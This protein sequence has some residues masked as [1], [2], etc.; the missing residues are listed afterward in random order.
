[1]MRLLT[2]L[3]A[4]TLIPLFAA[5]RLAGRLLPP[6][7]DQR[8]PDDESAGSSYWKDFN[9]SYN[10]ASRE[11][12]KSWLK[13]EGLTIEDVLDSGLRKESARE[14]TLNLMTG[15]REGF[16][17]PGFAQCLTYA[18]SCAVIEQRNEGFGR[19]ARLTA[20]WPCE[21]CVF[22]KGLRDIVL[23]DPDA[24]NPYSRSGNKLG[25]C[26]RHGPITM[27]EIRPGS[28]D[29]FTPER[30]R[31]LM[32]LK[33]ANEELQLWYL[34]HRHH[35]SP[36]ELREVREFRHELIREIKQETRKKRR[37]RVTDFSL[38]QRSR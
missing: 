8:F 12:V 27:K 1:V 37:R 15:V 4:W 2:I 16:I 5:G 23:P 19:S 22:F 29:D 30:R 10:E 24:Q 26:E 9:K 3:I 25:E 34:L 18:L 32:L 14:L 21:Y 7:R 11:V 36:E 38:S 31:H 28:C 13:G 6:I 17:D 20:S 33:Q 35:A